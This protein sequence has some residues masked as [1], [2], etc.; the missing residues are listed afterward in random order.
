M[1]TFQSKVDN[2]LAQKHIAVVGLSR[3][4]PNPGNLVYKKLKT[5]GH[6]MYAVNPNA[7]TIEGDPC[8]PSVQAIPQR[9]DAVFI[10]TRPDVTR[11]VVEDCAAAGIK[12]VWLHAS[13]IHGGTSFSQDAVDYCVQHNIEVIE[14]GCPMMHDQPV[15]FGHKCMKFFMKL[16]GDLPK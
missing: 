8:Y 1:S 7:E 12:L 15:D 4:E 9:P 13:M 16:T 3:T 6:T 14:G 11:K 5:S 2:F 10:A